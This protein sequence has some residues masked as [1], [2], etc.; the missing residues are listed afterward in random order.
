ML[1]S[2]LALSAWAAAAPNAPVNCRA[3][4]TLNFGGATATATISWTDNST[5]ETAWQLVYNTDGSNNYLAAS[6][7]FASSSPAATGG[8]FTVNWTAAQLNK[9][10]QFAI[11]AINGSGYTFSNTARVKTEDLG[12]PI[13]VELFKYD[14]FNVQLFWEEGSTS[15]NGFSIERKIGTGP[16]TILTPT[17]SANTLNTTIMPY[18][19]PST[20]FSFRVRASPPS[21]P[22]RRS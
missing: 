17:L 9:N 15:E 3:F 18:T 20:E 22:T 13:Y 16:W 21:P 8:T 19:A 4:T 12:A 14:P 10:Y 5:N 11:L 6:S 7:S 2:F 1:L